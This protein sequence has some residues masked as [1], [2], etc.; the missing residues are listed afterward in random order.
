MISRSVDLPQPD[1]PMKVEVQGPQR[2][3]GISPGARLENPRDALQARL[4]L[5]ARVSAAGRR[6]DR[7]LQRRPF[8]CV[9]QLVTSRVGV[10]P[11]DG[12][13]RR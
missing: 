1:G 11:V 8:A 12:D 5:S 4:Q 6:T 3:D 9:L 10:R 7:R 13:R 2:V